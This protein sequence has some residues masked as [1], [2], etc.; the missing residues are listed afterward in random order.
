MGRRGPPPKPTVLRLVE[1]DPGKLGFRADEAIPPAGPMPEPPPEVMDDDARREWMSVSSMLSAAGITRPLDAATVVMWCA[2][3]SR[4]K[5][6]A[7]F[8]KTN[9]TIYSIKNR[10]GVVVAVKEF[11]QAAEFRK[12]Q[13][14]LIRIGAELGMTPAARTR[15]SDLAA[16][17]APKSRDESALRKKYFG[18]A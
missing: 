13:A 18:G 8:V 9:G 2:T 6:A 5:K 1:G 4:W 7:E 14:L 12:L 17:G 10:K 3:Y 15:V 16:G 11:P